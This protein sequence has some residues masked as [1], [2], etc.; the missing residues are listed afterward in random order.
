[1]IKGL[2]F[3][4]FIL[5]F[6]HH[7]FCQKLELDSLIN[8]S[9][10]IEAANSNTALLHT[11]TGFIISYKDLFFL[12]SNYHVFTG[13]SSFTNSVLDSWGETPT[14]IFILLRSE[15]KPSFKKLGI[16]LYDCRGF[17]LFGIYHAAKDSLLDI[18]VT[19][20]LK[21]NFPPGT[22][23]YFFTRK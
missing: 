1:M 11:G 18:A 13:R 4:T 19:P 16:P 15:H 17:R 3:L 22:K 20:L 2:S 12:V 10:K 21:S 9:Y 23:Q 8:Y 7:S 5:L 14:I 6:S